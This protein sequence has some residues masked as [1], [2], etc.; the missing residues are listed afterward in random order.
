MS[1]TL[2]LVLKNDYYDQV[3]RGEKT[4]ELRFATEYWEKRLVGRHYEKV[5]LTRGY[6]SAKDVTKRMVVPWRGVIR[7][8]LSRSKTDG[9]AVEVLAIPLVHTPTSAAGNQAFSLAS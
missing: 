2:T 8:Q 6:P 1:A 9:G 4:E 5:V 3:A 7:R